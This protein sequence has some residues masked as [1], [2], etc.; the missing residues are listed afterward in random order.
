[1]IIE[2]LGAH[3]ECINTIARW[4]FDQWGPLTGA[5][6]LDQ[7][8]RMLEQSAGSD[9]VPCVLVALAG[10]EPLGSASL[11]RCDMAIRPELTPWLAQ[12][13]VTPASR[14]RGVGAAL[15]NAV[16][17][18]AERCGFKRLYLYTSG[19]LPRYYE[20]LGWVAR[21]R[22]TYLGR[23]RVVMECGIAT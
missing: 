19:E 9:S 1:M 14:G 11:V 12:L 13:F 4:H 17:R 18:R 15:V 2:D 7:Y 20:R 3:R 10:A 22:V 16:A 6:S 23:E 8:V 5:D 21:E